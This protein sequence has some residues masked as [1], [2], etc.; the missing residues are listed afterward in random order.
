VARRNVELPRLFTFGNRIPA[1]VGFLIALML[2]ASVTGWMQRGL[3]QAA[4]F[5]PGHIVAGEVWRLVTWV[6]VQDHPFTLL[7]GGFML[8]RFGAELAFVWG[9]G[10]LLARFFGYTVGA[11]V[12]VTLVAVVW[13]PARAAHLGA[14]PV[15]NALLVS[16]AL[17]YPERQVN[18]W[19]VL[20]LT[21]KTLALLVLG[22][23]LLYGIAGGGVGGIGAFSLHLVALAAA[24][25]LARGV[26]VGRLSGEAKLWWTQREQKRRARHLKV[27]HKGK[28]RDDDADR[29]L[30]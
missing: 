27:V 23:T 7:F 11:A 15:I 10:R 16:W 6:F 29:W 21:G 1:A 3:Q 30:N 4:Y 9:E 2:F 14:W 28:G 18:I 19:G 13:P 5:S 17:L 8:W 26:R 25:L 22:G 20:P 24:W 12:V